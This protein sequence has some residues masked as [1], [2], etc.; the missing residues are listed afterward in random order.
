MQKICFFSTN[1]DTGITC[2]DA[3]TDPQNPAG[4]LGHVQF[5]VMPPGGEAPS[6]PGHNT[7]PALGLSG[8][9][10]VIILKQRTSII[11]DRMV[12]DPCQTQNIIHCRKSKNCVSQLNF[13]VSERQRLSRQ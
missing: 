10:G 13:H 11:E 6:S 12:N 9:D 5:P 1:T 4:R 8:H 7:R 3:F 2:E